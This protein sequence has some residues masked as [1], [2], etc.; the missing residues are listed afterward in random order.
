MALISLIGASVFGMFCALIAWAF[1]AGFSLIALSYTS[2]AWLL[3]MIVL[4][5]MLGDRNP[6][7]DRLAYEIEADLLALQ[8]A[9]ST[10]GRRLERSA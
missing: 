2:G 10:V 9:T 4:M 8:E 6:C 7:G 1:G 3:F 5:R